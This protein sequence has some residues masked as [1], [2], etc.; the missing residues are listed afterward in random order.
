MSTLL[1]VATPAQVRRETGRL[2][3]RHRGAFLL[4]AA[5]LAAAAV[6]ALAGPALLGRL[7][8]D[9]TDG[10]ATA[11]TVDHAVVLLAVAVVVQAGLTW[12]AHRSSLVLGEWVFAEMREGFLGEVTR[13]PLSVVE[14][15]GGGDLISRTTNDVE[16]V[17]ESVR[18]AMPN[19]VVGMIGLLVTGV[20]VLLTSPLVGLSVLTGLLLIVPSTVWYLRRAR[21]GYLAEMAAWARLDGTVSETLDGARTVAALRLGGRRKQRVDE[22]LTG[23]YRAERYTL[24]LR[25]VWSPIVESGYILPVAAVLAW[26]GWLISQGHAEVGEVT[27]VALYVSQLMGPLDL[28]LEW[29]DELQVGSAS[30]ARIIGIGQVPDDREV[31][32]DDSGLPDGPRSLEAVEVRYSYRTDRPEDAG[33]DVL[34]GVSLT[35]NPG[36]RLAVVG[37]SGAGKSTLGRL[38]AGIHPPRTGR[39]TVS[40]SGSGMRVDLVDLPLPQLR[41]QAALVTQE[42]HVFVGTLADNLR[43]AR[44]EATPDELLGAL[45]AV[46]AGSWAA[47][48]PEGLATVV[49]SGGHSLTPGQ[50]QQVALARLVLSDPH[51]LVLDEAT[52]LLDPRAARH[53]ERSLSAVLTGRTV[54]A[55]AHRLH[56]AHD[57]DRVAVVEGGRITELGTHDELLRQGGSYAALW[58]SWQDEGTG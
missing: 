43:L 28:V 21:A 37:P 6:A 24:W 16:S 53:L 7:V 10:T 51:T 47:A 45:A 57:A 20:A 40:G 52:S 22:D 54:V 14:R 46:D 55:V 2:L 1:P 33:S 49:G 42:Q 26:G 32:A 5:T 18:Y 17:S 58:R 41:R 30:L 23:I 15:A 56:T 34:H 48:L 3:R 9:F 31:R 50:A 12:Y 36:E 44:P 4:T 38:L 29:M 35:L 25:T 39:V 8:Q 11:S 19:I 13:L 27:T